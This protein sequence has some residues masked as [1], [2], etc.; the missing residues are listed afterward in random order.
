MI[1]VTTHTSHAGLLLLL[2]VV[3]VVV[4]VTT[5]IVI[6]TKTLTVLIKCEIHTTCLQALKAV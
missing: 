6:K 2:S 4:V 3:V 1:L 5:V